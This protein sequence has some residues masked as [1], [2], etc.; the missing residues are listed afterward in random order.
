M[1]RFRYK[2]INRSG[3]NTH[4]QVTAPDEAAARV[5]LAERGVFV[6]QIASD[7]NDTSNGTTI[8]TTTYHQHV[9]THGIKLSGRLRVEL[10]SQLATALQAQ[11]PLVTA[12]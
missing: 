10:I 5:L 7:A 9:K 1:P 2:A 6:D 11:L 8:D 12:L 3:Q 4:G